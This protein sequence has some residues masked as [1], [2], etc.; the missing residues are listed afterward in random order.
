[1]KE[2]E[3]E[4]MDCRCQNWARVD[5]NQMGHCTDHHPECE[6]FNDSL[7]DVFKVDIDGTYYLTDEFPTDLTGQETVT[8]TT[9]HKEVYDRL[10]EFEGF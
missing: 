3:G 9:I 2:S 1:M 4:G 7:I 6:H 8:K 5:V 10:P